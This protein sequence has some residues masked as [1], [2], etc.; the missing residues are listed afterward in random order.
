MHLIHHIGVVAHE[1]Q[2]VKLGALLDLVEL[3]K[4]DDGSRCYVPWRLD[5]QPTDGLLQGDSAY[6][7]V[8]GF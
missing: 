3:I 8:S 5:P 6:L 4:P 2:H 7:D 1:V